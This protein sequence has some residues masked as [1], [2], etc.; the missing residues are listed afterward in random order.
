MGELGCARR[1]R[2]YAMYATHRYPIGSGS[3]GRVVIARGVRG[4]GGAGMMLLVCLF[5]QAWTYLVYGRPWPE[6]G[7]I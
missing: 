5:G 6:V 1:L 2:W 7:W 3:L 4:D